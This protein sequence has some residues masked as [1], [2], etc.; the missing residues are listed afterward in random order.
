MKKRTMKVVSLI[1]AIVMVVA[2]LPLSALADED[3][4]REVGVVVYGAELTAML[5]DIETIRKQAKDVAS[6]EDAVNTTKATVES[7]K[8]LATNVG[9]KMADGSG[10]TVPDVDLEVLDK[11]QNKVC[12]F[13]E[14]DVEIFTQTTEASLVPL[15]KQLE[16]AI[17]EIERKLDD[18][19][20]LLNKKNLGVLADT[21]KGIDE[22]FADITSQLDKA[23]QDLMIGIAKITKLNGFAYRTYVADKKLV[24]G[25]SYYVRVKGFVDSDSEN[26]PITR[27]GYVLYNDGLTE[28]G[29]GYNTWRTFEFTVKKTNKLMDHPIQFVGPANGIEG[30][31]ELPEA[32]NEGYSKAAETL[33]SVI[34]IVQDL[35]DAVN[36]KVKDEDSQAKK[37]WWDVIKDT[38]E[39]IVATVTQALADLTGQR[40]VLDFFS[41]WNLD[42]LKLPETSK[43]TYSFKFPG[44]WCAEYDAGFAFQN[45]DVAEQPIGST[46]ETPGASFLLVNRDEV[47]N[48]LDFMIG[49]GKDT[50]QGLVKAAFGTTEYNGVTYDSLVKLHTQLINSSEEGQ[51]TLDFDKVKDIFTVYVAVISDLDIFERVKD[52]D[53]HIPAILAADADEN[54]VVTFSK[55]SNVTLTWLIKLIPMI[56]QAYLDM[57]LGEKFNLSLLKF[58]DYY[59]ELTADVGDTLTDLTA[60][61]VNTLIYPFAQRLG[62]VGPKMASGNYL[63]FQ[64]KAP[65][66]YM[67]NP[68]VYTMKVTWDNGAWVYAT[69]AELGIL[70]PYFAEGLYEF[71]RNTSFEGTM[72]KVLGKFTK[73]ETFKFVEKFFNKDV[74]TK[75]LAQEVNQKTFG[76]VGAYLGKTGFQ[77]LKLDSIFANTPEFITA[78][79]GYLYDNGNSARNVMIYLNQQAKKAKSVYSGILTPKYTRDE[80][81]NTTS[82]YYDTYWNFYNVDSSMVTTATKLI[83]KSTNALVAAIGTDNKHT[84]TQSAAVQKVG[85]AVSQVV[86]NVGTKIEQQKTIIKAKVKEVAKS[87]LSKAAQSLTSVAKSAFSNLVTNIGKL[88]NRSLITFDA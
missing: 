58:Y 72:D 18:L 28:G 8:E 57:N 26:N 81:G 12:G 84:A 69:V 32:L 77:A 47:V 33:N 43:L 48:I 60:K 54:G 17:E 23:M 45:V 67:I 68:F 71:V 85:N 7:L 4:T 44:L 38:V 82:V 78:L 56:R 75:D 52:A 46:A 63:M 9:T 30:S 5:T 62:L 79:N 2:M 21:Y 34:D 41:D 80:L 64:Y 36:G 29:S 20:D 6:V 74:S 55:N 40:D 73:D 51:M 50:F 24:I 35:L 31:F 61:G 59:L 87:V 39:D 25:E 27:D 49:L 66:N 53:L 14:Q 42:V 83:Q 11:K 16:D 15:Q 13:T 65:A 1:L 76:I 86:T 88:F 19:T 37:H 10:I 3:N 70:T 22:T